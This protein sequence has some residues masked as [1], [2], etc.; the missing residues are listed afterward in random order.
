M[1]KKVPLYSS[2]APKKVIQLMKKEIAE[3]N[4]GKRSLFDPISAKQKEAIVNGSK[5]ETKMG[6]EEPDSR[7]KLDRCF[8]INLTKKGKTI[9]IGVVKLD[10][11]YRETWQAIQDEASEKYK[12]FSDPS[13]QIEMKLLP[14]ILLKK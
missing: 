3:E 11:D 1:K 10:D 14:L 5:S 2:A 13:V 6:S 8:S 7:L 9:C 4:N 12:D